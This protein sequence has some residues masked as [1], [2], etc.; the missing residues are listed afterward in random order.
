E[1]RLVEDAQLVVLREETGDAVQVSSVDTFDEVDRHRDRWRG[2]SAEAGTGRTH[3]RRH[4]EIVEPSE[5]GLLVGEAEG[6][7]R[8]GVGIGRGNVR[9]DR[10][11]EVEPLLVLAAAVLEEARQRVVVEVTPEPQRD[12]EREPNLLRPRRLR[13]PRPE[14]PPARG[15]ERV[16]PPVACPRRAGPDEPPRF[17]RAKLPVDVA[18]RDVPEP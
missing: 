11:I 9:R 12:E 8:G 18:R 6:D 5:D 16:R 1:R 3:A 13:D 10:P 15:G 17:E 14:L 4:A 7:D 2:R